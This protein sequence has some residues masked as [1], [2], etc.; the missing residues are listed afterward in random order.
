MFPVVTFI[1]SNQDNIDMKTYFDPQFV[2]SG[3][4]PMVYVPPSSGYPRDSWP[5]LG[6]LIDTGKRIVVFIDYGAN[7]SAVNYLLP[8]FDNVGRLFSYA[9]MYVLMLTTYK[10]WESPFSVTDSNFPCAVDRVNGSPVS[11]SWR[12][13]HANITHLQNYQERQAIYD[14]P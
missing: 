14:K 7:P 4:Q 11:I 8:Q 1:L 13:T 10:M 12:V 5:T 3:L 2:A 9:V 6:Q